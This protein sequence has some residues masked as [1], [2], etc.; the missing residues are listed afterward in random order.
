QEDK[1]LKANEMK[2]KSKRPSQLDELFPKIRDC[3]D[4]GS[5]RQSKHA[6]ERKIERCIDL[7][8]VLY[9]LKNGYHEKQKTSFDETFNA[10][11]YAIRG[12]TLDNIDI[13]IIIAFDDNDMLII[14]VMHVLKT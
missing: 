12:K 7:P 14:T 9:V 3:I 1:P 13:R 6:V 8:D 2:D 11:K 4:K 10:W 5:Y